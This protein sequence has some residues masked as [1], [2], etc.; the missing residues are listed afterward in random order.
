MVANV[1]KL[2]SANSGTVRNPNSQATCR[3]FRRKPRLVGEI[4]AAIAGGS[5]CT[6]SGISQLC[7]A[8]LNSAKYLQVRSAAPLRN[9]SSLSEVSLSVGCEGRFNHIEIHL[10][11]AQSSKMGRAA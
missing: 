10:L 8:V 2:C 4:R 6:L 5:S 9:N 3:A 7:S 11:Q 1:R